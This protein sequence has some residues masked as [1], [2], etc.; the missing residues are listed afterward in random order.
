MM[1]ASA[2]PIGATDD[3]V[4]GGAQHGH[5][6]DQQPNPIAP[7]S[8]RP[9]ALTTLPQPLEVVSLADF[10]GQ[11]VPERPWIVPKMIPDR[12]VTDLSADGGT[13][14]SLLALQLSIAMATGTDWIGHMPEPGPSFMSRAKTSWMSSTGV[15]KPSRR[16]SLSPWQAL[17]T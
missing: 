16:A 2:V 17:A 13:G 7:A 15:P 12:N 6:P 3:G 8:G 10:A 14:K 5:E 1:R 9:S 4:W 11:P